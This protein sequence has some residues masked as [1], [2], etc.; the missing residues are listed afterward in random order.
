MIRRSL[1]V[2]TFGVLASLATLA[3][4]QQPRVAPIVPAAT[5]PT[6]GPTAKA[7]EAAASNGT[8][9]ALID[10][11]YIFRKHA[12]YAAKRCL[13][14]EKNDAMAARRSDLRSHHAT[15]ATTDDKNLARLGSLVD[16]QL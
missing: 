2:A 10:I 6:S 15:G 8:Q 14:L 7:A 11:G 1:A 4:A 3:S 12:G 9:V 16:L 5:A 13:T